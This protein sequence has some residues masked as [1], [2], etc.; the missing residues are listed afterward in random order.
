VLLGNPDFT[1]SVASLI[2]QPTLLEEWIALKPQSN[3]LCAD[4]G[5][6]HRARTASLVL[7]VRSTSQVAML[8]V[9]SCCPA[10][11]RLFGAQVVIAEQGGSVTYTGIGR[12]ERIGDH[13]FFLA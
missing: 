10:A 12:V 2:A 6:S 5:E 11:E 7:Q 1:K 4:D 13:F 8:R 9:V 3:G